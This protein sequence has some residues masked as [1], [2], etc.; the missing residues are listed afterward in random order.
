MSE[1][2][3]ITRVDQRRNSRRDLLKQDEVARIPG[4]TSNPVESSEKVFAD[5]RIQDYS[6]EI[7][8]LSKAKKQ[9]KVLE[10]DEDP[11]QA[12]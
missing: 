12:E 5:P 4:S 2:N 9:G 3:T 10:I 1:R 7:E 11:A 8:L 6:D